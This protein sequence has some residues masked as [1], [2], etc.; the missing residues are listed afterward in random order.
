MVARR[1]SWPHPDPERDPL[2]WLWWTWAPQL[3]PTQ[4]SR[5]LLGMTESRNVLLRLDS[6]EPLRTK[7]RE[8]LPRQALKATLLRIVQVLITKHGQGLEQ[9]GPPDGVGRKPRSME[10]AV[11]TLLAWQHALQGLPISQIER[12]INERLPSALRRF[13]GETS[14]KEHLWILYWTPVKLQRRQGV[15]WVI[16]Q[17]TLEAVR[18]M[19]I[20]MPNIEELKSAVQANIERGKNRKAM[21]GQTELLQRE[22][23]F[24]PDLIE[25]QPLVG[26]WAVG[27]DEVIHAVAMRHATA[28]GVMATS[29]LIDAEHVRALNDVPLMLMRK[30]ADVSEVGMCV[31][32]EGN[33]RVAPADLVSRLT[34]VVLQA[35]VEWTEPDRAL[36]EAFKASISDAD[37]APRRSP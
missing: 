33:W 5:R 24:P 2:Y 14:I 30:W 35:S 6:E 19:D 21:P 27:K 23:L 10:A 22:S 4:S 18:Q 31:R 3:S 25:S 12:R 7:D 26:R 9:A 16:H 17:M 13:S 20:E 15:G 37:V 8:P 1:G 11:I 32:D 29:I 36:T 34:Q 28:R